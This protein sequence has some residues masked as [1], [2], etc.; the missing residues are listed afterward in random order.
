MTN[1]LYLICKGGYFYRPNAQGYTLKIEEAGLFTLERARQEHE[2][3]PDEVFYEPLE[4]FE[5]ELHRRAFALDTSRRGVWAK[6]QVLRAQH[7][8]ELNNLDLG[9]GI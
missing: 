5:G 1:A 2:S 4:K 7:L 9:D 8:R 6:L 3:R